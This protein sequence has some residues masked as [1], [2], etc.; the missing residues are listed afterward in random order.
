MSLTYDEFREVYCVSGEVAARLVVDDV[1]ESDR[2]QVFA[3]HIELA[4]WLTQVQLRDIDWHALLT[5]SS[6]KRII[7]RYCDLGRVEYS[8][9]TRIIFWFPEVHSVLDFGRVPVDMWSR[10]ICSVSRDD[11]WL[12]LQWVDSS[13]LSEEAMFRIERSTNE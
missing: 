13:L 9:L 10:I 3:N 5:F 11:Y 7:F 6:Y 2:Y 8:L 1:I 4:P 12:V